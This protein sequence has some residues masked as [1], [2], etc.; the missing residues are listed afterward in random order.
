MTFG[1]HYPPKQPMQCCVCG[2]ALK[3]VT[4]SQERSKFPTCG[5]DA[6]QRKSERAQKLAKESR[7]V[8]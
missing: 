5:S 7:V 4:R 1:F 3:L 2:A 8:A 6:C